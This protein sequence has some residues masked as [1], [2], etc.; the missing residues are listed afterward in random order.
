MKNAL[1]YGLTFL[2][3][4]LICMTL[5]FLSCRIPQTAIAQ[6]CR[7]AAE[8]FQEKKAKPLLK[9]G[10]YATCID[11][12]A[13]CVLFDVIWN[14]DSDSSFRSMITA[15][16]YRNEGE[17]AADDYYASVFE[18]K[19]ANAEYSR[20]WHGSQVFLRPLLLFTSIEGI[21]L[22][23]FVLLLG[24]NG[25]L[26]VLLLRQR[27]YRAALVYFLSLLLV[28]F[29]ITA[30]ALEYIMPF[31]VMTAVCITA[32]VLSKG[33]A[34]EETVMTKLFV[35]SG[36]VTC[37]LDFLTTETLTFTVPLILYLLLQKEKG[38]VLRLRE[39]LW[40]IVKWGMA[41]LCSYGLMFAVKWALVYCLAGNTALQNAVENAALKVNGMVTADGTATGELL[42]DGQR[43]MM[44][45]VRNLLCMFP[46]DADCSAGTVLLLS[47]GVLLLTGAVF[48][49]FRLEKTDGGFCLILFLAA[50]LPYVRYLFLSAHAYAHF[51]FTYRAQMATVM[52]ALAILFYQTHLG[53]A[54][55]ERYKNLQKRKRR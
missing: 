24:L 2:T 27:Y 46:V 34:G 55:T 40:Q 47:I 38:A 10:R 39:T 17:S 43:M 18:G 3:T 51:F 5:L 9:E 11:N 29:W 23:L 26:L 30:Y 14:V 25:I 4:L 36:A 44:G 21:R 41:W 49:L 45:L 22:L 19:K 1:K 15:P 28:Q 16:Y 32:M 35:V 48:Y 8:Y 12:Y 6:N 53:S 33:H 42:S 52:A 13:D 20:Y 37:F 54:G 31:L 50:L 7:K